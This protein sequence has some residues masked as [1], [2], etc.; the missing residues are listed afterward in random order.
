MHV[1]IN[2]VPYKSSS[3]HACNIWVD[4]KILVRTNSLGKSPI[5]AQPWCPERPRLG[6]GDLGISGSKAARERMLGGRHR[7]CHVNLNGRV[8]F[9]HSCGRTAH[10]TAA[11]RT[12]MGDVVK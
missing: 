9:V 8:R 5:L 6:P 11:R 10:E 4:F 7:L 12:D 2:L 3:M 1:T